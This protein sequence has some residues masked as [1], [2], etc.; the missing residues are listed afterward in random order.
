MKSVEV[1]YQKAHVSPRPPPTISH[2]DNWT[3]DLDSDIARSSNDIQWIELKPI[4]QL[5]STWKPVTI[6]RKNLWNV[7]SLIATLLI[8]R[9][10]MRD[11]RVGFRSCWKQQRLPTN[12]TKIKNPII[13]N[14]ETRE[15]TIVVHSARG[16]RHWFQST[17]IVTCSCERKQNISEFKSW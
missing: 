3:C 15:W 12:P 6:W 16:N 10:M 4:T 14:G 2:K 7:P 17:R 11:E 5:S 1:V 13:K 8:K 9:N